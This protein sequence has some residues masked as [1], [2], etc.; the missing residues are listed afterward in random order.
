[1]LTGPQP[2]HHHWMLLDTGLFSELMAPGT[3][4]KGQGKAL[5]TCPGRL[6]GQQPGGGQEGLG[7]CPPRSFL[8][9]LGFSVW[10]DVR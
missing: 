10:K 8:R 3:I 4:Q 9:A 7:R 2:L 5:W 6:E 1:M